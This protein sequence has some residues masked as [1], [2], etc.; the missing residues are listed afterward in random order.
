VRVLICDDDEDIRVLYRHAFEQLG[1]EVSEATNGNECVDAAGRDHPDLIVLD[2]FMPKRDGLSALPDIRR[3]SP[4]SRVL[5]VSAHAA[6]DVF[7]TARS[8]GA[9]ACFDKLA[10]LPRIPSL[11]DKYGPAA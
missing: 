11:I 5:V 2:L 4:T 3:M 10:F 7:D 6:V 9:T 1:V 8:R